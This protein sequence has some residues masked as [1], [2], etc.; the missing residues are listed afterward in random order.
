MTL[1]CA[2]DTCEGSPFKHTAQHLPGP[3]AGA[4]EEAWWGHG[5]SMAPSSPR[6][7]PQTHFGFSVLPA[8]ASRPSPHSPFFTDLGRN[9]TFGLL[10]MNLAETRLE[11]SKIAF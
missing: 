3:S 1:T 2:P 5:S 6:C 9:K 4:A 8:A 10:L 7:S 11:L